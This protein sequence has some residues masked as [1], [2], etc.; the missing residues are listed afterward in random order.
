M[1]YFQLQFSLLTII[2]T[3]QLIY[4]QNFVDDIYFNDNEVDYSFLY[5]DDDL[6][7]DNDDLEEDSWDQD[8]SYE[9]RIKKF[10]NPYY[11]DYYWDYGWHSPYWYWNSPWSW[12][13]NYHHYVF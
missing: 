5:I 8:I 7:E 6:Q 2:L 9:D 13:L 4:S 10:H 11:F 3:T 12:N 1:K